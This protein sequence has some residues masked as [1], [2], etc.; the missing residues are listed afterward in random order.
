MFKMRRET[1][2]YRHRSPSILKNLDGR[3]THVDHWFD[4]KDHSCLQPWSLPSLP[5]IRHLR[6]FMQLPANPM[7]DELRHDRVTGGLH[8]P[9]N[10]VRNV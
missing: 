5:I 3:A 10:R 9:L 8:M 4:R 1:P 2:V 6:F 7:A